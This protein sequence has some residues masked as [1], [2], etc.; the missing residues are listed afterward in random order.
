MMLFFDVN[1]LRIVHDCLSR[2]N[3]EMKYFCS[4][5]WLF[6]VNVNGLDDITGLNTSTFRDEV[7]KLF[8]ELMNM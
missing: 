5:G 4:I 8:R 2:I 6:Y 7:S 3:T 1:R